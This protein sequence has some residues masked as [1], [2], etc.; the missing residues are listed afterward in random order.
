MAFRCWRVT[1]PYGEAD[2][3]ILPFGKSAAA[4]DHPVVPVL[5]PTVLDLAR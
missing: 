1:P 3:A 2:H 4:H 5:R